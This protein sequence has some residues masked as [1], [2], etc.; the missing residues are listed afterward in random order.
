M[1]LITSGQADAADRASRKHG[2]RLP[3]FSR[4]YRFSLHMAGSALLFPNSSLSV[5]F[6]IDRTVAFEKVANKPR[7]RSAATSGASH[8]DAVLESYSCGPPGRIR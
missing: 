5:N 3:A 6:Y 1:R 2:L 8:V 4:D 7:K